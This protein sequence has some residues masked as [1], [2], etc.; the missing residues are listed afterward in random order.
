[1]VS[2]TLPS[3]SH[4]AQRR[5]TSFRPPLTSTPT[6]LNFVPCACDSGAS[7]RYLLLYC[8][9]LSLYAQNHAKTHNKFKI[10]PEKHAAVVAQA[11]KAEAALAT[12][13][14]SLTETTVKLAAE[15]KRFAAA[16]QVSLFYF[17]LPSHF[18]R[19]ILLTI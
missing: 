4:A 12:A 17:Y 18:V 11:A 7:R 19:I 1:M 15:T 2:V 5:R 9:C 10:A 3:R 14:K 8:T 16:K 13:T 6:H